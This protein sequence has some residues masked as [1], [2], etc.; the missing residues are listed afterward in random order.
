M[1]SAIP[2]AAAAPAT[3]AF[4]AALLMQPTSAAAHR[5]CGNT[6]IEVNF[7]VWREHHA[8]KVGPAFWGNCARRNYGDEWSSWDVAKGQE[9]YCYNVGAWRRYYNYNHRRAVTCGDETRAAFVCF[10]RAIPCRYPYQRN[11]DDD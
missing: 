10:Y 6:A 4:V 7:Q 9:Y 3:A 1:R 5:I 8:K 2:I 11:S